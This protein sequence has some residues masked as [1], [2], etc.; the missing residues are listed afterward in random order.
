MTGTLHIFSK[1]RKRCRSTRR[2]LKS[3]TLLISVFESMTQTVRWWM[4]SIPGL[5]LPQAT[6]KKK[7]HFSSAQLYFKIPIVKHFYSS[8]SWDKA[9][10]FIFSAFVFLAEKDGIGDLGDISGQ[11]RRIAPAPPAQFLN[12]RFWGKIRDYYYQTSRMVDGCDWW[13]LGGRHKNAKRGP[14]LAIWF[15]KVNTIKTAA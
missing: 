11:P 12:E 7:R 2:G 1:K 14:S 10:A 4:P 15:E 9:E 5:T 13:I 3:S 8:R 6:L